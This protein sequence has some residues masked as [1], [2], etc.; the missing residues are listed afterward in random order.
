M[1]G[2]MNC[3][4]SGGGWGNGEGEVGYTV[5]FR[6][7]F[8]KPLTR[9]GVWKVDVPREQPAHPQK[10]SFNA[11]GT[12]PRLELNARTPPESLVLMSL[13]GSLFAWLSR[14]TGSARNSKS[15]D[16][17]RGKRLPIEKSML[18]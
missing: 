4:S 13:T 12:I 18:F 8:S 3:P 6:S 10:V 15:F 14:L 5:Y 11:N 2:W 16:S 9:F 17:I 7:E 1:E